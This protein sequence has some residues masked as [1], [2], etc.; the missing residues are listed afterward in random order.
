[1]FKLRNANAS[2]IHNNFK[3][4]PENRISF[5]RVG[6]KSHGWHPLFSGAV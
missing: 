2:I 5:D 6:A 3:A 1:M 4:R